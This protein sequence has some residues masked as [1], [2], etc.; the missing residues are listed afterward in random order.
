MKNS[1]INLRAWAIM[2]ALVLLSGSVLA[3][4]RRGDDSRRHSDT[5]AQEKNLLYP[6][7]TRE[8]PELDLKKQKES[9]RLNEGLTAANAGNFDEA[10]RILEPMASGSAS[11]SKYVQAMA[12][13]GLANVSYQQKNVDAAIDKLKE[14]LAI[15]V[16]PNDA[17]FQLMYQ[18]A[19]FYLVNEQYA[20]VLATVQ[21]WRAQGKKETAD[22]YA[23]EG[24]AYYRL[25][26][27]SEAIAALKKAKSM[28]GTPSPS[29]DQ[30]LAAS[31]AESGQT[32]EAVALAEQEIAE[33]PGDV[34]TQRNAVSLL[35][36]S[37]RYSKAVEIMENAQAKGLLV[38]SQDYLNLAKLH[39]LIGQEAEDP[40]PQAKQSMAVLDGAMAKG[41]LKPGYDVYLLKGGAAYLAG[42]AKAAIAAYA[43]AAEY[44]DKGEADYRRGQVLFNMGNHAAART[45]I[46]TAIS[47]GV[48]RMGSAYMLL[49]STERLLKNK[50]AAIAAVRKAAEFPETKAKADE[51]L[52]KL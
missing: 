24:N 49:G 4:G 2:L 30:L 33:S 17:Y 3:Q 15:G 42:D 9:D 19:Q 14:A 18:L 28:P 46:K 45:A 23:L 52:R 6:D 7:T 32:D 50:N 8:E 41:A 22:S 21:E 26:K 27:Y 38:E 13:Q 37:Q 39:M 1:H 29:W 20:E 16:M 31:Y 48:D 25:Q 51:W 11:E 43:K 34:T 40:M 5:E 12:L 35:I 47:K 36:N 44:T 10:K